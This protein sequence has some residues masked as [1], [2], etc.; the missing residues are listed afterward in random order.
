[1]EWNFGFM[2]YGPVW[3]KYRRHFVH[4]F[5]G[6]SVLDQWHPI[7]YEER[8]R[9]LSGLKTTP[10]AFYKHLTLYV[11]F[12][13][14]AEPR[15]SVAQQSYQVLW[16]RHLET[17]VRLRR[18]AKEQ[19]DDPKLKKPCHPFWSISKAWQVPRQRPPGTEVCSRVGPGSG[20]R[21]TF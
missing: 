21:N 9:L 19:R 18:P 8:D 12:D 3:R 6:R 7:M 1:M 17:R 10:E 15:L 11:W 4:D 14:F 5:V 13:H 16:D 20:I 2:K